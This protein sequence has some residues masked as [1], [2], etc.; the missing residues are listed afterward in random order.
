MSPFHGQRRQIIG[1]SLMASD[2]LFPVATMMASWFQMIRDL[3]ARCRQTWRLRHSFSTPK[4][5]ENHLASIMPFAPS[6]KPSSG[7]LAW[8]SAAQS[9]SHH[10]GQKT[11]IVAY[12]YEN[13]SHNAKMMAAFFEGMM[14]FR[15]PGG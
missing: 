10:L 8:P 13:K 5:A 2:Y 6:L 1:A 7:H 15:K 14:A 11:P 9:G 4:D 3:A 12:A